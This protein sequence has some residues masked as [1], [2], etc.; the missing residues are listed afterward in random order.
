METKTFAPGEVI[1]R[2][3]DLAGLMYELTAGAVAVYTDYGAPE[4]RQLT[5]FGPGDVFGELE[6]IASC[7]RSATAVALE[8]AAARALDREDFAAY[9]EDK[10][11]RVLAVMGQVSRRIRETTADYLEACRTVYEAVEADRTGD[12]R[13]PHLWEKLR[14]FSRLARSGRD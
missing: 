10:P 9:L 2:Q 11:D 7:P 6:L 14:L 4:E 8:D 1:F 12:E 3:G 5:V 13:T